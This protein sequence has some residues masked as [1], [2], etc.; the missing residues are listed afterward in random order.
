MIQQQPQ[1]VKNDSLS[2]S[3]SS[4][5]CNKEKGHLRHTHTGKI[6]TPQINDQEG[7]I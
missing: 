6:F 1:H 5:G 4:K 7:E 2:L 3:L